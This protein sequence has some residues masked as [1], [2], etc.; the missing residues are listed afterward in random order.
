MYS[1][2]CVLYECLTGSRPYPGD[3]LEEQL[4]AH[5][6]APPPRPSS[7]HRRAAG[8]D[9]VVAR[10]MAKDVESRYQ[11]AIELAEAARAALAAP[12]GAVAPAHGKR[13]RSLRRGH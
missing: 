10:G 13:P 4:N 3:S 5:V 6:N 11:S 12:L 8:L 1:L 7:P 2:A 9:A